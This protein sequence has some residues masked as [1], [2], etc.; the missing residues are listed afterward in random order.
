MAEIPGLLLFIAGNLKFHVSGEGLVYSCT[1]RGRL[2][3]WALITRDMN[4]DFYDGD[5]LGCGR[6]VMA[7]LGFRFFL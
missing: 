4:G 7:H 5:T 1:N 6:C 2:C 3:C